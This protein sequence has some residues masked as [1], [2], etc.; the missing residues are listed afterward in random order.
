MWRCCVVVLLLL[1]VSLVPI[2]PVGTLSDSYPDDDSLDTGRSW[3]S[4]FLKNTTKFTKYDI[5]YKVELFFA[6]YL[7]KCIFENNFNYS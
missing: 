4:P 1:V 5:F 6:F 7:R 3:N 2:V